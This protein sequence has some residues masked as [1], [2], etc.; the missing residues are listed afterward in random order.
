MSERVEHARPAR[1]DGTVRCAAVARIGVAIVAALEQIAHATIAAERGR[2]E[3]NGEHGDR[4]GHHACRLAAGGHERS[5]RESVHARDES[6]AGG[7]GIEQ[8]H[9]VRSGRCER[10]RRIGATHGRERG[11]GRASRER[12]RSLDRELIEGHVVGDV[13]LDSGQAR[14]HAR[15]AAGDT[16]DRREQREAQTMRVRPHSRASIVPRLPAGSVVPCEPTTPAV[17]PTPAPT[18][19]TP[20][21][22]QSHHSS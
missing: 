12:E 18:T 6:T 16:E 13:D 19:T 20:T 17:I 3:M 4:A 1:L 21:I 14:L 5:A 11:D 8:H 9:D 2:T 15:R 7:P 22:A 10:A